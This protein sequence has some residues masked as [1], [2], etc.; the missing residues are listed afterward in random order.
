MDY[1]TQIKKCQERRRFSISREVENE[2]EI[3]TEGE[4][5]SRTNANGERRT[6]EGRHHQDQGQ[7]AKPSGFNLISF[8]SFRYS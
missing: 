5:G 6:K 2:T 7:A 8:N 4:W 3:E 1:A